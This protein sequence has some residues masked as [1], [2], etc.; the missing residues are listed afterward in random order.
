MYKKK[1]YT[2]RFSIKSQIVVARLVNVHSHFFSVRLN[3]LS[4]RSICICYVR[5]E[6]R[7]NY[8]IREHLQFARVQFVSLLDA[9]YK[10]RLGKDCQTLALMPAAAWRSITRIA[11]RCKFI[12]RLS[13]A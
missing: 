9:K 13:P 5:G 1:I 2:V 12:L 11:R 7:T 8:S 6:V 4:K 10:V 3:W